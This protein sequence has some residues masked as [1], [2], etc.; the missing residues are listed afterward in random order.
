[1][2]KHQQQKLTAKLLKAGITWVAIGGPWHDRRGMR[3]MNRPSRVHRYA[4]A[5]DASGID[6]HIWGYPWHDTVPQFVKR[7]SECTN[8]YVKG[9]LLDPEL[10]LKK[11]TDEA[12]ALYKKS[13]NATPGL[14]LG[15]TSYGLPYGH[16]TFPWKA[17]AK[18]DYGSPQL[19]TYSKSQIDRIARG[20]EGWTALGYDVVIPSFGTYKWVKKDESLPLSS[21]NRRGIMM[22][23]AE[24]RDHMSGFL[25]CRAMIGW[26]ENLV[27]KSAIPVLKEF[28]SKFTSRA[29]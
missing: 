20:M 25:P 28:S 3:W 24:L 10:G 14:V 12:V 17:F 9:W 26:A 22:S 5:I 13:R 16:K 8:D 6:V 27:S 15:M 21:T 7:M 19:Y 2:K 29:D 23:G 4:E 11:H 1:L 18:S